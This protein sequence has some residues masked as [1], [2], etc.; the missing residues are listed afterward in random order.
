[1][2]KA[3]AK[4]YGLKIPDEKAVLLMD[5]LDR[6]LDNGK[7]KEAITFYCQNNCNNIRIC[8]GYDL[9]LRMRKIKKRLGEV[10][11]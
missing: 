8:N 2:V 4:K 1:M 6:L 11:L 3:T 10:R 5:E 9:S 7:G